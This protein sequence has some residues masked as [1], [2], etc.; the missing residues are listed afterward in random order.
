MLFSPAGSVSFLQKR[1][2]LR[3]L[4]EREQRRLCID[5]IEGDEG[6]VIRPFGV[7]PQKIGRLIESL[8]LRLSAAVKGNLAPYSQPGVIRPFVRYLDLRA[9]D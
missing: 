3:S 1:Q 8:G 2:V 6:L 7:N 5:K 4:A 9:R